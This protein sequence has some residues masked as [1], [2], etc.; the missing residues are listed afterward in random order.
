MRTLGPVSL[1]LA[2]RFDYRSPQPVSGV[3]IASVSAVTIPLST[4]R[5]RRVR[6]TPANQA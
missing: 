1:D 5:G 6:A 3:L 4:I 2:A